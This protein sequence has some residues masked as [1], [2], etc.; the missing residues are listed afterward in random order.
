MATASKNSAGSAWAARW[1]EGRASAVMH[2]LRRRGLC[3]RGG[4]GEGSG[5]VARRGWST[6]TWARGGRRRVAVRRARCCG[7]GCG[8][9]L[10][11]AQARA[12]RIGH[13]GITKEDVVEW[14]NIP[15]NA[16]E[17]DTEKGVLKPREIH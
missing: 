8:G 13:G 4:A 10:A 1:R 16:I 11:A 12:R 9:E 3:R 6:A 5:T 15:P 2:E 17:K 14:L 7:L